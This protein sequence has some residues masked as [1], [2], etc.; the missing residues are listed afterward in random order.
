MSRPLTGFTLAVCLASSTYALLGA[1]SPHGAPGAPIQPGPN[2]NAAGGIADPL[3]PAALVKADLNQQRQN[4]TVAA[5]STRNPDHILA[6]ANDYRFVDFPQD[7]FFGGG[8]NFLARLVARL[9]GK[10]A[11]NIPSR[12]SVSVGAWT[13]IYRSCDRGRT[14][15][16][17]AVPGGPLDFS[18]AAEQSPL[19]QLSIQAAAQG[20]HAETTDPVLVSGP[21]GRMHLAVLGFV[22]F[23]NGG[24]GDS[25]MYYVSYTDRNNREG[26]TC[27]NYDFAREIDRAET[28]RASSAPSPFI[29]KPAIAID[30][31]GTIFVAYTA[32]LDAVNS[33]IVL[34]RS[35]DG[36]AT[37][38]RTSPLLSVGFLRNH[39]ATLAIDPVNGNVYLA[40]RAFF[41]DWPLMMLSKS[42]NGKTFLPATPISEFWPTRSLKQ[43]ITQLRAAR[44]HPFDQFSGAQGAPPAARSLAFPTLATGVVNGR[45]TLFAA[46]TERADVTP[47]SA[48]FGQ[49]SATGS[50]RVMLSISKDGGRTWTAR[51]A[52]DAGP[53]AEHHDQPG[54]GPVVSRPSV[55]QVQPI[56]SLTGQVNP[57]LLLMY[58]EA[59]DELNQPLAS[60]FISGINRLMDVRAARIN[61][62]TGA[63]T[64]P[65]VQV[66]RY[67]VRANTSPAQLA[68]IAPGFPAGNRLNLTMYSGGVA[69]FF[70]DYPALAPSVAF[71]YAAAKWRWASEPS[72]TLAIWTDHRDVEFP[73]G[74]QGAPDINGDWTRY[75]P[76]VPTL[77]GG[78]LP[79]TCSHV[80]SRNA[81]PYF[82][83]LGGVIAGAPQTFK[84]LTIQR[85]FATYVENRTPDDR[86]FRL[87]IQDN[88]A[89]GIDGS[90]DQ[91]DFSAAN[92]S[93]DVKVFGNSSQHRTVWVQP[94]PSNP[95]AS[96]PVLV[97]EISSSGALLASGLRARFVLNP[98]PNNAALTTVPPLDPEHAGN[99]NITADNSELH[100]PQIS[101][102][103][104]AT[105]R[106]SA[107]QISSPQIAT[108]QIATTQI[109]TPQIST[110]QISTPQISSPQIATPQ[111]S[112]ATPEETVNG[113][114]VTFTVTNVGTTTTSYEAL[115][116]VP[117]VQDLIAS[118]NYQFQVLITRTS[119]VPGYRPGSAGGCEPV[120]K[121]VVQVVSNIPV[122]QISSP[123]IATIANPQIA[124]PQIATP[125]IAT[126]SV[127]P[128]AG[129]DGQ[130]SH[131]DEGNEDNHSATLPDEVKVTLRAIRLR[132]LAAI[133]ADGDTE[134]SPNGVVLRV[135][136]QSTN[137]ILGVVQGDGTQ[138]TTVFTPPAPP[139]PDFVVAD[140][141]PAGAPLSAAAGGS[142][143]LSPWTLRNQGTAAII[144]SIGINYYLST[145]PEITSADTLLLS[146]TFAANL[147]AGGE[148]TFPSPIVPIPFATPAGSYFIGLL[149]DAADAVSESL[150]VNN[151]VSEPIVITA[152]PACT[153]PPP[154]MVSWW[155]GDGNAAD[156][157]GA[158]EGYA[159]PYQ[160]TFEAGQVGPAF[161]FSGTNS[162]VKINAHS[163]LRP[164]KLTI[165]FWF[166]PDA[167]LNAYSGFTPLLVNAAPEQNVESIARG[168]DVFY[169]GG[170]L[171]FRL[172]AKKGLAKVPVS[173]KKSG[174]IAAGEWHHVAGTFD[175]YVQRLYVDGVLASSI[176]W[177]TIGATTI[178]YVS[179]PIFFGKAGVA[180]GYSVVPEYFD[181]Q[182]DE[183][184]LFNRALAIGEIQAI[185]NAGSGGK[186]KPGF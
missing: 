161:T 84:P 56:L 78:T 89:A 127:A 40:W 141:T 31:A 150:E 24:V 134:F 182:L 30:P 91:F 62:A 82:T 147:P 14:W 146:T 18:E 11:R 148:A 139:A 72:S 41:D 165:D 70:G 25:R 96:V 185:V 17:S 75:E 154:G 92:D 57:Q 45:S 172:N 36:G 186:C 157:K 159:S 64:A 160:V 67:P 69:A 183:V 118:G 143:T 177:S 105:F 184:E 21:G 121:N 48:T 55:P 95:T 117:D 152:A 29:D 15:V 76:L 3:D 131:G 37:W 28:Y 1:Q 13:G 53:R 6:A 60:E 26:G 79:A 85:A 90:F 46:W 100:N 155:P 144:A 8:Q 114:D 20:G 22:R 162:H 140:Y 164:A 163:S 168:Y 125:Q 81:N 175:G 132:T 35:T 109:P 145:D 44:L 86:F 129:P 74:A 16:G 142:V 68:E 52:V 107:P 166:R 23:A 63:L 47:G 73:L 126:F 51:R 115:F 102:P 167:E 119:L 99:P 59:R 112:T 106:I 110:P 135:Q 33:K 103:Q 153:P 136:S 4:E 133:R 169:R 180:A 173:V 179:S 137:V 43:I 80:A 65:S 149:V 124:T 123:Q 174:T 32:F 10:P 104:I 170:A 101:T 116:D 87:T 61:P 94:L 158:N 122:P 176:T 108:P 5:A 98:D 19:K 120:A 54:V 12:A 50:P 27:F 66:S 39:G 88:E 38:T 34:A 130:N 93:I 171:E 58:Y 178:S 128:F 111:I 156:I 97:Q 2:I 151:F 42:P 113:T 181:G 7:Q 49:P 71:E 77:P 9:F 138:P 83:E